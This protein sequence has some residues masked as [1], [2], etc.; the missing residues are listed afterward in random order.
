MWFVTLTYRNSALPLACSYERVDTDSG[1]VL[2]HTCPE[3]LRN[4]FPSDLISYF[5]GEILKLRSS[6]QPRIFRCEVDLPYDSDY[7]DYYVVTPSLSRADVRVWLKKRRIQFKRDFGYN[8]KFRYGFCGEYGSNRLRPHYHMI[9]LDLTKE[10]LDYF[11]SDWE[12]KFGYTYTKFVPVLNEDKSN[13]RQIVAKY[14]GKYVSKGKFDNPAV[15]LG[16]CQKG[17]LCNSKRFGTKDFTYEE[18]RYYKCFDLYGWYDTDRLCFDRYGKRPLSK[19]QISCIVQ[20]IQNRN[21]LNIICNGDTISL[22][23]PKCLYRRLWCVTNTY[24]N[25]KEKKFKK[26]LVSPQIL[27][28]VSDSIQARKLN[29]YQQQYRAFCSA[30]NLAESPEA[31][32]KFDVYVKSRKD[33][34]SE[35]FENIKFQAKYFSTEK[36]NQ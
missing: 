26:R 23:M 20:E 4:N 28:C 12:D 7:K 30:H 18:I 15:G 17:R 33:S 1:E 35:M 27:R 22:P 21:H 31:I 10:Q 14:V 36:D 34:L 2:Y 24:Y 8:V 25:E 5:R 32:V 13:A 19:E 11:L 3:V 9:I 6:N 16:M 29:D